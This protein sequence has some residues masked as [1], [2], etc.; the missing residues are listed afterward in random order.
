MAWTVRKKEGLIHRDVQ[1]YSVCTN[2]NID[3]DQIFM[4]TL[5]MVFAQMLTLMEIS[6]LENSRIMMF[7]QMLSLMDFSYS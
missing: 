3:G 5:V 2:V 4:K 6:N 7:A 1:S